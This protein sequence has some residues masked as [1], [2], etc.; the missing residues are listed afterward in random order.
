MYPKMETVNI[1]DLEKHFKD[2]D[3]VTPE[4][5]ANLRLIK[6]A[7]SEVKILNKGK[8]TKKLT[9]SGCF[10]SKSAEDSV[11]KAGGEMVEKSA[12]AA[13]SKE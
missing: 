10:Y 12:R 5:L 8:L 4:I 3:M 1:S 13:K 6:G 9:L 2:G 7:Q 11:K